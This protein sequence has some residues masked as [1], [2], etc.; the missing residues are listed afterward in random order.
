MPVSKKRDV[1]AKNES[2]N[3]HVNVGD[4]KAG[5]LLVLILALSMVAGLLIAAVILVVNY[6]K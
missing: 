2:A 5:K 4:S 1:P 6:L 3:K